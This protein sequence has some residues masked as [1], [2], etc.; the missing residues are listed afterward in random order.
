MHDLNTDVQSDG[1]VRVVPSLEMDGA[2]A[3]RGSRGS[4][5]AR[6][7]RSMVLGL[8]G[9]LALGLLVASFLVPREDGGGS[10]TTLAIAPW[11]IRDHLDSRDPLVLV[12]A[13]ENGDWEMEWNPVTRPLPDTGGTIGLI[14]FNESPVFTPRRT[15]RSDSFTTNETCDDTGC[16]IRIST[17]DDR[18]GTVTSV[19]GHAAAWHVSQPGT[20]VWTVDDEEPT[21]WT[22]TLRGVSYATEPMPLFAM[23]ADERIVRV[24]DVGF[25]S[26]S[27]TVR[28]R[29]SQGVLVWTHE[30]TL[31]DASSQ[32]VVVADDEEWTILNR[33]DGRV[34]AQYTTERGLVIA[35]SLLAT[36]MTEVEGRV[37]RITLD[38][39]DVERPDS[40]GLNLASIGLSNGVL[41]IYRSD[42]GDRVTFEHTVNAD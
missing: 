28:V 40:I 33:V 36:S 9:V 30:A 32:I 6:R 26:T 34:V 7:S 2:D 14:P 16:A 19:A 3:S 21:A 37:Q 12:T 22:A 42:S 41:R 27:P 24:D 29:D 5:V 35:H 25:V 23:A 1:R 20:F 39:E 31:I 17:T 11:L 15:D 18:A 4:D 13:H 8:V 10:P 38:L